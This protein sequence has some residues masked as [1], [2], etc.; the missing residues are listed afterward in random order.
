MISSN[1]YRIE[2]FKFKPFYRDGM[3]R[4]HEK[5]VLKP[6]MI[7]ILFDNKSTSVFY[8]IN[9]S[10]A[11]YMNMINIR[12]DFKKTERIEICRKIMLH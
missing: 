12:I 8:Y 11:D 2:S 10:M 1:K 9:F 7:L 3:D 5:F 6:S 4:V